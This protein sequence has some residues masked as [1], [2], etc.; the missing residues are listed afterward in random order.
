MK[1]ISVQAFLKASFWVGITLA[2]Y[3]CTDPVMHPGPWYI[4]AAL[5]LFPGMFIG[6]RRYQAA[7]VI[8]F[9][10]FSVAAY[11]CYR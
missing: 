1:I 10:I 5:F 6:R 3:S 4:S 9:C 11:E 8:L 7:A 2:F